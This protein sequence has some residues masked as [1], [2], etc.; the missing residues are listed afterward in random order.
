VTHRVRWFYLLA[1]WMPLLLPTIVTA[2]FAL[3]GG[4]TY[5]GPLAGIGFLL[6]LSL[7]STGAPY[8]IVAL[9][10]TGWLRDPNRQEAAVRRLM[11]RAPVIVA[12][13]AIPCWMIELGLQDGM[14]EGLAEGLLFYLPYSLVLGYVYVGA[15]ALARALLTLSGTLP[16][17]SAPVA[18]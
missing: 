16:Q 14:L 11:W 8:L 1:L 13:F 4:G 17:R 18:P 10:V 12:A 9:W 3:Q 15:T 6:V 2:G 5:D 7:Y